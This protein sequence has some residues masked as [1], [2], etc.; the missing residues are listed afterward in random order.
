MCIYRFHVNLM[1]LIGP[2]QSFYDKTL[3]CPVG[4]FELL[5]TKSL[6]T[7]ESTIKKI[8]AYNKDDLEK[9]DYNNVCLNKIEEVAIEY[10]SQF[11][12]KYKRINAKC[13]Y[14]HKL[15]SFP[16]KAPQT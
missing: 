1:V 3:F 7:K 16:L 6:C 13:L 12:E 5:C 15:S 10:T 4:Y 8:I 9:M 11:F 2:Y 14:Y